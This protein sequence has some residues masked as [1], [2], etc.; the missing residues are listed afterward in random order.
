MPKYSIHLTNS[1]F[2]SQDDPR[3][4]ES[5][6]EAV[7]TAV[8]SAV[9]IVRDLIGRNSE[10]STTVEASILEGDR[11]ITRRIVTVSTLMPDPG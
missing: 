8:G 11:V 1:E 9:D 7:Q 6:E 10:I 3:D 4:Y 5:L 2:S